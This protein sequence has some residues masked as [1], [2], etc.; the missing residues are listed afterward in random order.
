VASKSGKATTSTQSPRGGIADEVTAELGVKA[1]W[2]HAL[3][4]D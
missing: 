4:R 2:L 1:D 3:G